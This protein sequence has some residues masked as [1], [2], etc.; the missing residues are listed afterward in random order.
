MTTENN[1]PNDDGTPSND[2][3]FTPPPKQSFSEQQSYGFNETQSTP[4]LNQKDLRQQYPSQSNNNTSHPVENA[5]IQNNEKQCYVCGKK[6][7]VRRMR[8]KHTCR[9]CNHKV[10]GSCSSKKK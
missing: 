9:R 4:N 2:Q 1:T 6:F 7:G 3:Q 5:F 10:C 8:R